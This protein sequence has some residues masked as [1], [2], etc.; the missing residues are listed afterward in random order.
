M[1]GK[2]EDFLTPGTIA[3][4]AKGEAMMADLRAAAE[5]D[6]PDSL[7]AWSLDQIEHLRRL[8]LDAWSGR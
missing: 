7:S 1:A 5:R 2:P 6:G 4:L 3:A 8:V